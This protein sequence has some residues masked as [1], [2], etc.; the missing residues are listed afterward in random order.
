MNLKLHF[1]SVLMTA[2]TLL[3]PF[4]A[5]A[6]VII[7]PKEPPPVVFSIEPEE[8]GRLVYLPVAPETATVPG[9]NLLGLRLNIANNGTDDV[10]LNQ[11]RLVFTFPD[12]ALWA[13]QFPRDEIVPAG[14]SAVNYLAPDEA[15]PL[16]EPAPSSV[17]IDLFFE[18]YT[19]PK[20]L[21]RQ[22]APY[23]PATYNGVYLFPG[24]A[25]DLGPDQYWSHVV[26]HTGGSQFFG[27]DF[28]VQG[29]DAAAGRFSASKPGGGNSNE[30]RLAWNVPVYAIADGIVIRAS[31]G[32]EDNPAPGTRSVQRMGEASSVA[33]SDVKVTRFS[34]TRAA[35]V[36]RRAS[37]ILRI[38]IWDLE[39]DGRQI[40]ERGSIDGEAVAEVAADALTDSR[41]V[42]AVRTAAGSLRVIVWD[43]SDD[44]MSISRVGERDAAAVEEVS[45]IKVST[46]RFA[47][48]VRTSEGVLRLILWSVSSDG[49]SISLLDHAFAGTASSLSTVALS[50]S[51]L[52]TALRAAAG[53]LKAIVWDIV[54]EPGT[55]LVRLGEA[56]GAG[57]NQVVSVKAT[58][59]QFDT[60]ARRNNQTLEVIRWAVSD[61]GLTV[62]PVMNVDAGQIQNLAAAATFDDSVVTAVV[63]SQGNFKNIV[64]LPD[65]DNGTFI[66]RGEAEAGATD[67][68]DIDETDTGLIFSGVRTAGGEL[69]VI[70][71][72]IGHGGGN[73]LFILHGNCRVL[74]AHFK[75][76]TVHPAVGFP[77]AVVTAGQFLGRMGNSGSSAGP[78]LH[79]HAE[80][81]SS[82]LSPAE[83]LALESQGDLPLIGF[84][85]M[86]FHCAQVMLLD[87]IEPGP[88]NFT[89]LQGHGIY[90]DQFGI[91]PAWL[92]E[93]YV[94]GA[95]T[96]LAPTGRQF[97]VQI[98]G[99]LGVGGPFHTVTQ[100]LHEPCWT[101][102]LFIRGGSYNETVV[103]DRRI[104]VESYEGVAIIGQ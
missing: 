34:S 102:R 45:L 69:K 58:G 94:N 19:Q 37:G 46:S 20:S 77:G 3:S 33:I 23:Q 31:L 74:Y 88:N 16:L 62:T 26:R 76:G 15:F 50:G 91:R 55:A 48:A 17:R 10:T 100:A 104:V 51:R 43:I 85:P 81:V 96:C 18:G 32:W 59:S 70:A 97:C 75:D 83:I 73:A 86:P 54:E 11:L 2:G 6:R 29:W 56:T 24:N 61:D 21:E 13:V 53:E 63:T 60:A 47:T 22:L 14:K 9:R 84:R 68:L 12:G 40:F 79:I 27:Y 101:Q 78:H 103:F 67:R 8:N 87:L 39:D 93:G 65:E 44:G 98:A 95:S 64:W 7:S 36:V 72:W 90:F 49:T 38:T 35:T 1:G 80:R 92:H 28:H 89:S 99:G 82:F 25:S 71:W 41:L 30:D 42:T 66:R 5:S 57:V 4:E 52:V